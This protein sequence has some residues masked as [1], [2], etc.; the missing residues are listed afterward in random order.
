MSQPT[1]LERGMKILFRR[2]GLEVQRLKGANTEEAA[3]VSLL[4]HSKPDMVL[5]VGANEGQ[6]GTSIRSLGF[7]GS[8]VSFEPLVDVHERLVSRAA[9]DAGWTV[10][11]RMGLGDQQGEME[12]NVAANLASSS[13]LPMRSAHSEAAPES[14]YVG[15]QRTAVHRLD[16]LALMPMFSAGERILLKVDTQGYERAVLDGAEGLLPRI[17]ALQL[18]LS[19]IELYAG[20]PTMSQMLDHTL[21]LGFEPFSIVPGFKD[22]QTG[23]LLQM[24]GFFV[25]R[26]A[27]ERAP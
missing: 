24:E 17:V 15:V 19:L 3:V 4:A 23:R 11:P 2:A 8:I 20:A 12:I 6:Y 14:A 7:R 10:A 13:L 26:D 25:R 27:V 18:E 22:R 1:W 5:D 16:D 9:T 21:R